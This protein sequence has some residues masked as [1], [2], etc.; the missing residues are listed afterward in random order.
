[1]LHQDCTFEDT[2][3]VATRGKEKWQCTI[4]DLPTG[5]TIQL[6]MSDV[7]IGAVLALANGLGEAEPDSNMTLALYSIAEPVFEGVDSRLRLIP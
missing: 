5:L 7:Q 4:C 6:E 3:I 2:R 1:M